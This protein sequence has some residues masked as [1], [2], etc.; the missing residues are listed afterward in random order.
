MDEP[1]LRFMS[2]R[3]PSTHE[4]AGQSYRRVR[5]RERCSK[6]IQNMNF[7]QVQAARQYLV[8][9]CRSSASHQGFVHFYLCHLFT[10]SCVVSED[11]SR[12]K[13][14]DSYMSRRLLKGD[15]CRLYYTLLERRAQTNERG[16]CSYIL[17]TRGPYKC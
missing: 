7:A 15:F 8:I 14:A 11:E 6:E 9:G 2:L 13:F 12:G 16:V 10:D 1:V 5:S 4:G 3:Q 17:P